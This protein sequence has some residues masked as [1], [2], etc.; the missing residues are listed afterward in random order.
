MA[1]LP[2]PNTESSLINLRTS[3]SYAP[4]DDIPVILIP[5]WYKKVLKGVHKDRYTRG[6]NRHK[7]YPNPDIPLTKILTEVLTW[8][9]EGKTDAEIAI[10]RGVSKD[11]IDIQR[12]NIMKKLELHNVTEVIRY[13]MAHKLIDC[14]CGRSK[15]MPIQDGES[16]L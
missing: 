10:I 8:I 1:S 12:Y 5:M 3:S 13:A 16:V 2:L 7:L 6:P 15:S 11:T 9:A 4:Y 14:G